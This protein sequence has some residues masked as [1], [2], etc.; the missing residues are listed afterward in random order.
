MVACAGDD[1]LVLVGGDDELG[2]VSGGEFG[3]QAADG[4]CPFLCVRG[5][6]LVDS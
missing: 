1:E 6:G 3:E 2:A 5:F 4:V